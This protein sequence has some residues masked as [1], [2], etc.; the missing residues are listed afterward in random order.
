MYKYWLYLRCL[1]PEHVISNYLIHI[2]YSNYSKEYNALVF[3]SRIYLLE[4]VG[5]LATCLY[6]LI[7]CL[8]VHDIMI[9]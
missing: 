5:Y 2:L 1:L 7:E 3:F 9:R 8:S 4:Y 6:Y